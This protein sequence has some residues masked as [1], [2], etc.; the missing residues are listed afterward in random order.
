MNLASH[1]SFTTCR[2][3]KTDG[4]KNKY[5]DSLIASITKLIPKLCPVCSLGIIICTMLPT[6][7]FIKFNVFYYWCSQ[8]RSEN[9][10]GQSVNDHVGVCCND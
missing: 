10:T 4:L 3:R 1:L 8:C 2:L 7:H 5:L 6:K 9:I